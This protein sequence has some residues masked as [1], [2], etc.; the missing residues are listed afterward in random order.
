[1]VELLA[2]IIFIASILALVFIIVG[3]APA[4]AALPL[5]SETKSAGIPDDGNWRLKLLRGLE[6]FL[7]KGR[8]IALRADNWILKA[9]EEV[10][11]E[12]HK[13]HIPEAI[14][15]RRVNNPGFAR[16]DF[17]QLLKN[18]FTSATSNA[19]TKKD[20]KENQTQNSPRLYVIKKPHQT[21]TL[22]GGG[23][24]NLNNA[25]GKENREQELIESIIKDPRNIDAYKELGALYM[26]MGNYKDATA[27]FDAAVKL[28]CNDSEVLKK[29][30]E[31]K[32]RL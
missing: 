29:L 8:I 9:I 23:A 19:T 22:A 3:K 10:K 6:K 15:Q 27:S 13:F 11:K 2:A 30:E 1:M 5:D 24:I 20:V 4:L 14:F 32:K 12:T 21:E 31:V 26:T 18:T 16:G 25:A 17:F 28:G 7:R